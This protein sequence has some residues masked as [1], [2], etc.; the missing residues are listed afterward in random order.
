M[1]ENCFFSPLEM[2]YLFLEMLM[3]LSLEI[4]FTASFANNLEHNS[5]TVF[6]SSHTLG[7]L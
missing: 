4:F 2:A 3:M 6:F 1:L 5:H 7:I